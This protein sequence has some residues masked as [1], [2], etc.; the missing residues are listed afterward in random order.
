MLHL[1]TCYISFVLISPV[2]LYFQW[3]SALAVNYP[4]REFG[5]KRGDSFEVIQEKSKGK[6]VAIHLP[7]TEI[8]PMTA[9]NHAMQSDAGETASP[10]G[11]QRTL[12]DN[13]GKNEGGPTASLSPQRDEKSTN[14]D[15]GVVDSSETAY[16]EEF[17]QPQ[18]VRD[19][20]YRMEKNK[21]RSPTEGKACLDRYACTCNL[22]ICRWVI[23]T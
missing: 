19:E 20:M 22:L 14:A 21:M 15:D 11:R 10:N 5:I 7:V 16:N 8:E 4:A 18:D 2:H 12:G 6:C 23:L 1:I 17:N 13:V 3:R 9:T